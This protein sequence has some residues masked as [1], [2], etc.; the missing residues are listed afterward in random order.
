MEIV[1][2]A[3]RSLHGKCHRTINNTIK[4]R[5]LRREKCK[6]DLASHLVN[7][8]GILKNVNK[9]NKGSKKAGIEHFRATHKQI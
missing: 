8:Q 1:N 9:S 7:N 3:G 4:P 6:E 2:K 5:V